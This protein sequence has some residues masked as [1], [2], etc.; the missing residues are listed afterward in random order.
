MRSAR[1]GSDCGCETWGG[2][3][4]CANAGPLSTPGTHSS[5]PFVFDDTAPTAIYP[6]SLPDALPISPYSWPRGLYSCEGAAYSWKAGPVHLRRTP[7]SWPRRLNRCEGAAYSWK[8]GPVHFRGT[9]YSWTPWL[10]RCV[11]AAY[12][13]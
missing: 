12:R 11:G 13:W 1:G 6:L 5:W 10:Y 9:P 3:G 8:A 4:L 2:T 7:Y